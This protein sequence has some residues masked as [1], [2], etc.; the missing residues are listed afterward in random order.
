MGN[1]EK[2]CSLLI[3]IHKRDIKNGQER[4]QLPQPSSQ[5]RQTNWAQ[6]VTASVVFVFFFLFLFFHLSA[7]RHLSFLIECGNNGARLSGAFDVGCCRSC[8]I[9]RLLL[10]G[11]RFTWQMAAWNAAKKPTNSR[12]SSRCAKTNL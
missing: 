4:R 1:K 2:T 10:S 12:S 5:P 6:S 11:G 3:S 7:M 9:A 8:R